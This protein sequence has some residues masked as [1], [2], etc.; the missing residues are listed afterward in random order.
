MKIT[1]KSKAI[2]AELESPDGTPA[3]QQPRTDQIVNLSECLLTPLELP[4]L[5]QCVVPGDRICLVIDPTTPEVVKLITEVRQQFLDTIS[6]ELDFSLLLPADTDGSEWNHIIGS[7]P[8]DFAG[9][10]AIKIHDPE[11]DQQTVYLASTAGGSRIYLNP[12][13]VDADL[14]ITIGTIAWDSSVGLRGTTSGVYPT[15][16]D[17]KTLLE[18]R[19]LS[20]VELDPA[21]RHPRRET[22][23]EIG[24]LIGTQFAVQAIPDDQGNIGQLLCGAPD[25]VMAEGRRIL[26]EQRQLHGILDSDLILLSIAPVND[27]VSWKDLG[28]AVALAARLASDDTRIAVVADLPEQ[29]SPTLQ[30]LQRCA[31][32]EDLLKPLSLEPTHDALETIQLIQALRTSSIFLLSQLPATLVEDLGMLPMESAAE[33]QRLLSKADRPAVLHGANFL[34]GS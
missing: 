23:D 13:V 30:M 20:H 9:K 11:D 28:H 34:A 32:P 24:W 18:S 22:I 3:F 12:L 17:Q 8:A 6:T 33:L 2:R 16:S 14:I 4:R 19:R 26:M 15:M 7:L 25:A 31:E 5:S 10:T 1:L 27:T 21:D 29:I